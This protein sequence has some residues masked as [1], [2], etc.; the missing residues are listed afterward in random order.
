LLS[1]PQDERN[2]ALRELRLLH[3]K[4]LRPAGH[5][6]L[7]SSSP[8]RSSFRDAG[9]IDLNRLGRAR[10]YPDCVVLY[11]KIVDDLGTYRVCAKVGGKDTIVWLVESNEFGGCRP[12]WKAVPL[13]PAA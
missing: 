1:L 3:G 13:R 2:L 12:F 5:R 9:Q 6:K 8:K 10:H 11:E 7:E 4:S